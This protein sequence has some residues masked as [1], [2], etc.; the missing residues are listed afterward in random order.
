[1]HPGQWAWKRQPSPA[2]NEISKT[3]SLPVSKPVPGP[4]CHS[5]HFSG[6]CGD[7]PV[8][9]SPCP[10]AVP[11]ISLLKRDPKILEHRGVFWPVL[12]SPA[13]SSGSACVW[14][15]VCVW[16]VVPV[17]GAPPSPGVWRSPALGRAGLC[18][19]IFSSASRLPLRPLSKTPQEFGGHD[20]GAIRLVGFRAVGFTE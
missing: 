16:G 12:A 14:V 6:C 17:A 3:A 5:T 9:A 10:Q 13:P 8:P 1:M 20:H 2:S 4:Q 19:S 7:V 18:L 11:Q 15:C